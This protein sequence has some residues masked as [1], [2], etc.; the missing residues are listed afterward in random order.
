MPPSRDRN[1]SLISFIN[2]DMYISVVF[3]Y[4]FFH[5]LSILSRHY[6]TKRRPD[7]SDRLLIV[8]GFKVVWRASGFRHWLKYY[9]TYA[10]YA[11]YAFF[12]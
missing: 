8:L 5:F 2:A 1:A 7:T 9:Y 6:A 11:F 12:K 3:L 4:H 10:F